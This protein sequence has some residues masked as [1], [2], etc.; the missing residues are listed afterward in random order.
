MKG[1]NIPGNKSCC[2]ERLLPHIVSAAYAEHVYKNY[3]P[4]IAPRNP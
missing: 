3:T 2:P 1:K 4:F